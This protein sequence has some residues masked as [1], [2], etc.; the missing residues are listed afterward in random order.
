MNTERDRSLF[1]AVILHDGPLDKLCGRGGAVTTAAVAR[2]VVRAR[3]A[4]LERAAGSLLA[5]RGMSQREA[6]V[7]LPRRPSQAVQ[8]A[9]QGTV[10]SAVALTGVGGEEEHTQ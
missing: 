7:R 4:P 10:S 6:G 3:R 8:G 5:K 1:L 2:M 9:G